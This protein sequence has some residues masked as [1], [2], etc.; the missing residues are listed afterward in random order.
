MFYFK[1]NKCNRTILLQI[2]IDVKTD[3]TITSK[4]LETV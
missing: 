1:V 2:Q 4:E 3:S